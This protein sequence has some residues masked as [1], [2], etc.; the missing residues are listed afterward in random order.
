MR[1]GMTRTWFNPNPNQNNPMTEGLLDRDFDGVPE[2]LLRRP[3]K[4]P[5]YSEDR[6]V[7]TPHR[8][9]ARKIPSE[10]LI[11]VDGDPIEIFFIEE[12]GDWES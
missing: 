5:R 10:G 7:L 12:R 2:G 9:R 8:K 4:E 3:A 1:R 6:L 11:P